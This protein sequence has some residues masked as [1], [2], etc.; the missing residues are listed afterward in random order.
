M[1]LR[2]LTSSWKCARTISQSSL[3]KC[4][5]TSLSKV[6]SV[7]YSLGKKCP[8]T[9][10]FLVRIFPYSFRNTDQKKTPYLDTF[11]AVAP[12]NIFL[13]L[14]KNLQTFYQVIFSKQKNFLQLFT[15]IS[16]PSAS[17][18]FQGIAYSWV[19]FWNLSSKWLFSIKHWT[20]PRTLC[21]KTP[22]ID[23]RVASKKIS[24][25]CDTHL[26]NKAAFLAIIVSNKRKN[27]SKNIIIGFFFFGKMT[28]LV[29]WIPL[30]ALEG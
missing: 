3:A 2:N 23:K 8:N 9:E 14:Q 21:W 16:L 19:H 25:W 27:F 1:S 13:K 28:F 22:K 12:K 10:F 7:K 15:K 5:I 20:A 4:L 30:F 29:V 6:Y 26:M 11:Y 17:E 18:Y 24:E